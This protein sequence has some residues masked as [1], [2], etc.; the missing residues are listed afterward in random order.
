[1]FRLLYKTWTFK[2]SFTFHQ[3]GVLKVAL[4]TFILGVVAPAYAEKHIVYLAD[5]F[6]HIAGHRLDLT[7]LSVENHLI[8]SSDRAMQ[9]F[10]LNHMVETDCYASF[11]AT[12]LCVLFNPK[13][14]NIKVGSE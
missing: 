1:M 9:V 11:D 8:I 3:F 12:F 2:K 5:E 13:T 4:F 7:N 6:Q 14:L 10:A